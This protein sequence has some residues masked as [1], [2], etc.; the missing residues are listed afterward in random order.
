M[1]TR[2]ELKT[3]AKAALR[4]NYWRAV[5]ASLFFAVYILGGARSVSNSSP[6]P[7][8]SEQLAA[9][10]SNQSF[11]E[12]VA[13]LGVTL[14]ALSIAGLIGLCVVVFVK[15]PIEVGIERFFV[16]CKTQEKVSLREVLFPLKNSYKN[17]VITMFLRGLYTTL[18][19]LLFIIPGIIKAFSWVLVPYIL[20]ERPDMQAKEALSLSSRMMKGNKWKLCVLSFSFIGWMI[21]DVL[22]FGLLDIF[23]VGP[24]YRLTLAEFYH[25]LKNEA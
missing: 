16:K 22:T 1:W 10:L 12:L 11:G 25:A 14:G 5:L 7:E 3:N 9:L 21:L 15:N 18:W 8:Q 2:K 23:Y 4:P 24:Y 17:V 6:T 20:A 13:L 19:T